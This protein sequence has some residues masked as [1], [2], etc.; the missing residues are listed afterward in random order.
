MTSPPLALPL[1]GEGWGEEE[2]EMEKTMRLDKETFLSMAKLLKLDEKD[3]HLEKL[4]TYV[5]KLFPS[6]KVAEGMDLAEIEPMLTPVLAK[7]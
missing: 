3:A 2:E 4:Y 7:E 1:E 6:F 5:E